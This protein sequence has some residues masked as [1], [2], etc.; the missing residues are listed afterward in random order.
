MAEA[1][2]G[3]RHLRDE[4]LFPAHADQPVAEDLLHL[5]NGPRGVQTRCADRDATLDVDTLAK[6][7]VRAGEGERAAER[8]AADDDTIDARRLLAQPRQE[9]SPREHPRG[10][11][12]AV[13]QRVA[14]GKGACTRS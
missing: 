12:S 7:I 2:E 4:I 6:E 8:V 14:Q 13:R 3:R 11:E 10:N 5:R 9:A 1:E